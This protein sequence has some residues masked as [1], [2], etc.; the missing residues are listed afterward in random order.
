MGAALD[1]AG[2]PRQPGSGFSDVEADLCIEDPGFE[3]D[4]YVDADLTAVAK[5]WLGDITFESA[6]RSG[7]VHLIGSRELA[8]AFP[9]WL[10][11]SHFAA[12]PRP[13]GQALPA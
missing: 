7:K 11:L 4:L 5:V 2:R 8:R 3:V 13:E 12:V 6:L 9:S 10:M 1:R